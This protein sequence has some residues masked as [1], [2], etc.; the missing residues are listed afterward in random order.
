MSWWRKLL[1]LC[2]H[3]WVEN[4]QRI[5]VYDADHQPK[6][7]HF[8]IYHKVVLKCEKCGDMKVVKI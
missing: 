1:G 8:P 6:H 5:A 3:K 7:G 4:G 2:D